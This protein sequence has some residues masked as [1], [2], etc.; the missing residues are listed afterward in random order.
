[1]ILGLDIKTLHDYLVPR[2]SINLENYLLNCMLYFV[3]LC[4][5]GVTQKKYTMLYYNVYYS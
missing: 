5:K 1:M 2:Y 3:F 4:N